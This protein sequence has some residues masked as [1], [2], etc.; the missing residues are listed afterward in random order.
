LSSGQKAKVMVAWDNQNK[1][2]Y[3]VKIISK[4]LETQISP[5]QLQIPIILQYEID[6]LKIL[7]GDHYV[8]LVDVG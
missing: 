5:K 7:K 4:T 2:V 3:A 8:Q 6:I 1:E